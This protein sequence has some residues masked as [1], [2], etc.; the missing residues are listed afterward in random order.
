V[1]YSLLFLIQNN[2]L[3]IDQIARLEAEISRH[4]RVSKEVIG[5][6]TT[7]SWMLKEARFPRV[8]KAINAVMIQ[9]TTMI[10]AGMGPLPTSPARYRITKINV[11]NRIAAIMLEILKEAV[12]FDCRPPQAIETGKIPAASNIWRTITT[13]NKRVATFA[14]DTMS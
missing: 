1:T 10:T 7:F 3:E 2:P 9:E 12:N 13:V 6:K 14:V 4:A 11:P 8:L 5:P